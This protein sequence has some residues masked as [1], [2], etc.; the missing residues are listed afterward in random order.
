MSPEGPWLAS[1]SQNC[2]TKPL[3][4]LKINNDAKTDQWWVKALVSHLQKHVK[5]DFYERGFDRQVS[6]FTCE[7]PQLRIV[8]LGEPLSAQLG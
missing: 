3:I 6:F 2:D 4:V 5:F 1:F 7:L 8:F